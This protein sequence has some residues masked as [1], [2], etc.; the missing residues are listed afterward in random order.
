MKIKVED[1]ERNACR[2]RSKF[3]S[4]TSR[5][6][7]ARERNVGNPLLSQSHGYPHHGLPSQSNSHRLSDS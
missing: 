3:G 4:E 7:N 6:R 1:Q 2:I 5:E